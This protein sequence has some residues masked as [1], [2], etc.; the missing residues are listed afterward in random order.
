MERIREVSPGLA[1]AVDRMR[2]R[3]VYLEPGYDGVFGV[4]R[5]FRNATDRAETLRQMSLL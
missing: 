1:Q 5:V 4:V 2:R 3:E